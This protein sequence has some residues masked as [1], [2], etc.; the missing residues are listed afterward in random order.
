MLA[1]VSLFL[2]AMG[3][4]E[5]ALHALGGRNL[6][7]YLRSGADSPMR[8]VLGG[9]AATAFLQSSS[10]V[11]LMALAFVGAGMLALP[12][13]L[14]IVFGSNLG[15]TL[16]GWLVAGLGFRFD[17]NDLAL[18]LIAL[19]GALSLAGRGRRAEIGR[20]VIGL[21]ILLL[22]LQFMKSSVASLTDYVEPGTLADLAPWQYL[23]FGVVFSAVIQSS[24]AMLM[25]TLA[26]LNAGIITLPNAA[27]I[28]IGANLG[29]TTTVI[30][31]AIRGAPAKRQVATAHFLFNLVTAGVAYALR[32]PLL[33]VIAGAGLADPLFALV[34]FHSLFNLIGLVIFVPLIVPLG[35]FLERRFVADSQPVATALA[36]VDAAVS[37]AALTAIE[38]ETAHLIGRVID[39]G[40]AAFSPP[41]LLPPGRAPVDRSPAPGSAEP[42]G[43]ERMYART[44]QLEG[45]ILAFTAR[46]Q[47]ESLDP[48]DSERLMRLL[49]TIRE[50][51][52]SAKSLK[53]IRHNLD[54]FHASADEVIDGYLDHF[55]GCMNGF[56]ADLYTLRHENGQ[57]V[58]FEDL[59]AAARSVHHRHDELHA[60]I[61]A[62]IRTGAVRRTDVSSLLNVNREI[63]NSN[64]ALSSALSLF[65]LDAAQADAFSRL[66]GA[67]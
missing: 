21:G 26:A 40:R 58:S 31:G 12:G 24:S 10:I 35:R 57:A 17:I 36:D 18:P 62:D 20:V 29:T 54:A 34:A 65:Y 3:Q 7:R 8:G 59:V 28:A 27:A 67:E 64:L 37:D 30:I 61:F 9:I 6:S 15:T 23:F 32:T 19:G 49:R 46:L 66:P 50:A 56:L 44:K 51:V 38:T 13:A 11:S 55:R 33:A 45:E 60:R 48:E 5:S 22:G 53:D 43:F 4:L 42:T 39:Q 63:L 47:A 41:L 16:T 14:A 25:I 1:G 52:H 2:F